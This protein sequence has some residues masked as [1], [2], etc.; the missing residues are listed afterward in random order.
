MRKGLSLIKMALQ[1][2][3]KREGNK[4]ETLPCIEL[5]LKLHPENTD[6]KGKALMRTMQA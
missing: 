6:K 2:A 4:L 3:L 1:D 5:V